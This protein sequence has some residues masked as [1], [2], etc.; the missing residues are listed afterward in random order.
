MNHSLLFSLL[1]AVSALA[2][3]AQATVNPDRLIVNATRLIEAPHR[4]SGT[5][6]GVAA[7]SRIADALR[8]AG[9]PEDRIVEQPFD[10]TQLRLDAGDCYFER[11]GRRIPIQPLRPNGLALPVTA[12]EGLEAE[13]VYLGNGSVSAFQDRVIRDRIVVMDYLCGDRWMNAARAGAAAILF[14]GQPAESESEGYDE[15]GA[16]SVHGN[17]DLPRFYVSHETAR[18]NGLL[19]GARIRLFSRMGFQRLMGRNL[20]VILPG[21]EDEQA[22]GEFVMLACHYDTFGHLPFATRNPDQAAN[23]AALIEAAAA[24]HRTPMERPVVVAFFDNE[25]QQ[26]AG[27]FMFHFARDAYSPTEVP[28]SLLR[29]LKDREEERKLLEGKIEALESNVAVRDP[30]PA[31]PHAQLAR[32]EVLNAIERL[33]NKGVYDLSDARREFNLLD[34]QVTRL[35]DQLAR[36]RAEPRGL[37]P[38]TAAAEEARLQAEFERAL[39]KR[40]ASALPSQARIEAALARKESLYHT[41]KLLTAGAA[42]GPDASDGTREVYTRLL[43]D[44]M[45]GWHARLAEQIGES[46]RLQKYQDM[47]G[48]LA[49]KKMVALVVWGIQPSPRQ[50]TVL[51][52]DSTPDSITNLQMTRWIKARTDKTAGQA[53]IPGCG[54]LITEIES[55]SAAGIGGQVSFVLE[56]GTVGVA[57]RDAL[58]PDEPEPDLAVFAIHTGQALEFCRELVRQPEL[59]RVRI[60]ARLNAA[61]VFNFPSWTEG[62]RYD[63]CYVRQYD[64]RSKAGAPITD[65]PVFIQNRDAAIL[66]PP[67]GSWGGTWGSSSKAGTFPL[68]TTRGRGVIIQSALLDEQGRITAI[69]QL[70]PDGKLAAAG[71]WEMPAWFFPD[72]NNQIVLSEVSARLRMAGIRAATGPVAGSTIKFRDATNSSKPKRLNLSLSDDLL[73]VYTGRLRACMVMQGSQLL[74]NASPLDPT[75]TGYEPEPGIM[76]ALARSARDIWM[77]DES[78]LDNLRQHNI[79]ENSLERLHARAEQY[80]DLALQQTNSPALAQARWQASQAYSSRVYEP[81][82]NVMNDLIKAVIILLLLAI[83][84]SFAVERVVSGSPN[85]YVQILGFTLC[86]GAVFTILY[87]VHPAFRFTS[88]P[89]VVLLAFIIIILSSMVIAIMW[90]K[91]EYEVRKLHGVA[92]ASHQST[93]TAQG[94]IAAAVTLGIATMRR[95]PLRT[96]LTALT[97]LLLTFTILFFG[98]FRS[99]EGIRTVLVGPG[100]ATTQVEISSAPGKFFDAPSVAMLRLIFADSGPSYIRSWTVANENRSLAGRLPDDAVFTAQGFATLPPED[101]ALY[102]EL[103]KALSG[104]VE[105]FSRQGGILL[106]E[107]LYNRI[108]ESLRLPSPDGNPP[109]IDFEG[110]V[111]ALRGAFDPAILKAVRTLDGAAFVPP[112]LV[113]VKR[114]LDIEYPRD[115]AAVKM[116]MDEMDLADLPLLDPESVVLIWEPRAQQTAMPAQSLVFLPRSEA[117]ARTIAAEASILLDRRV[118]LSAGGEHHRVLYTA[119]LSLGGFVKV[120]VPL[121]L[122][123]LIIFGTMLSSVSD[124]QK[125]IF[126]FS[127][128]GLGPRHVAALFF[129]E[130]SVYAVIGGM[131][132][133]LFAHAFSKMVEAMARLGWTESPAMNHSSMNAMLTLLIVMATV[134]ISTVYPAIK[135]SRSANPGAQRQWRMP[136]PDGDRLSLDFPFTVSEYDVIGLVSFLEEHFLSHHDKS[137]GL[138]A[139]DRVEVLYADGRFTINAMV[140]LQPFDQGVSQTFTLRTEPSA[141]EGID[142]VHVDMTRLSGSPAIWR[143]SS[144]VFVHDLRAQFILW[145]TIP[146]EASEHYYRLTTGRFMPEK[147]TDA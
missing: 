102:P 38:E 73:A 29:M 99:E 58:P 108:P 136:R 46:D 137:I 101:L 116:K 65:A 133:Y 124:R 86:F 9:I 22:S 114:Q 125:E 4:L 78:R 18:E 63:G 8:E 100:P 53:G 74:L 49:G 97:I 115:P 128:L 50:W 106:P 142:R 40:D 117:Q 122:G 119:R 76:D 120:I 32:L 35:K 60:P 68:L 130:A 134:L 57:Q 14:V 66:Q 30:R 96:A 27:Q 17:F 64:E 144:K 43:A 42:P 24:I 3:S 112:D 39:R 91:F 25:A 95:R 118:S 7:G 28:A 41:R 104:D 94:T 89:L 141:I 13:T 127:A 88:F 26:Q 5:P 23:V 54:G 110:R 34:R 45:D 129:A 105:A 103:R 111:H 143:R 33:Y 61:L 47:A 44:V 48:R 75:G 121:I 72:V 12:P 79:L 87:L 83:P 10:V 123:G 11:E 77:L 56:L 139:A 15:G 85:I 146:D 138:F 131:G 2:A 52:P 20:F 69:S 36:Y 21:R 67:P 70:H 59:S 16:K 135:A 140:W 90:S 147:G 145:R 113:E 1:L 31:T 132:G 51:G 107:A 126:T 37:A 82:R 98:S 80:M 71:N 62:A 19:G 92:T 109:R 84:F 93:R 6:E 81:V 55:A